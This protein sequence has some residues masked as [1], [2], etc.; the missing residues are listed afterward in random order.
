MCAQDVHRVLDLYPSPQTIHGTGIATGMRNDVFSH[1][2]KKNGNNQYILN[3]S[4]TCRTG[5][6]RVLSMVWDSP[7]PSGRLCCG[8]PKMLDPVTQWIFGDERTGCE[9]KRNTW[10]E[11]V[12][13]LALLPYC[14]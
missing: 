1:V 11:T 5:A 14:R 6:L 7:S 8:S 12:P 3:P 9:R 2:R 13:Y 10:V 4:M